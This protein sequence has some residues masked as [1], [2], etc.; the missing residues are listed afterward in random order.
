MLLSLVSHANGHCGIRML[1]KVLQLLPSGLVRM[2][3]KQDDTSSG[4]PV[5]NCPVGVL[6]L[7]SVGLLRT[8][9]HD[10]FGHAMV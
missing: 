5:L 2:N 1:C 7:S 10:N 4:I 8:N 9:I 3:L 6:E